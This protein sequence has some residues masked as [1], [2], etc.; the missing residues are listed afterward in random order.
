M[1]ALL[2]LPVLANS[3]W[4]HPD[5]KDPGL[6]LHFAVG[7][8]PIEDGEWEDETHRW[9]AQLVG[10]PAVAMLGP[11]EALALN[12]TTDWLTLGPGS[13]L[14]PRLPQ[15]E[16]SVAAWVNVADA[17]R[18]GGIAG[19]MQHDRQAQ[20]GWMLGTRAG[21]WCFALAGQ[22]GHGLTYLS[23]ASAEIAA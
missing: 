18:S 19:W 7:G 15:K 12:G 14:Q 10:K 1:I 13:E 16:L 3:S 8:H 21:R 2:L 22:G 5:K 20:A 17:G 6:V 4:A 11:T 23:P 9:T